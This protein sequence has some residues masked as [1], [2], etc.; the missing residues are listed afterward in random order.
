ME[1]TM[2]RI[3]VLGI[4]II[5]SS[6]IL[7]IDK[8]NSHIDSH[9]ILSLESGKVRLGKVYR[10]TL[11]S[12]YEVTLDDAKDPI[13][14]INA[15]TTDLY[16]NVYDNF[17]TTLAQVNEQRKKD[18]QE[19]LSIDNASWTKNAHIKLT[20]QVTY[21]SEFQSNFI[22]TIDEKNIEHIAND[23]SSKKILDYIKDLKSYS[24]RMESDYTIKNSFIN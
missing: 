4:I 16:S 24:S 17:T 18:K 8:I 11:T 14:S 21:Q 15:K 10:E 5:L 1:T 22:L 13:I 19:L 6:S 20:T 2:N 23:K 3:L 12:T 7:S 9:N